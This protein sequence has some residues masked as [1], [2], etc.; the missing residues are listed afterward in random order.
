MSETKLHNVVDTDVVYL[1][2]FVF[3]FG[4]VAKKKFV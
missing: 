4:K 1:F 2:M 3:F